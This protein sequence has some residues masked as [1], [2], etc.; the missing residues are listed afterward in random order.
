[1]EDPIILEIAF[2]HRVHP[3]GICLKR[4]VQRGVVPIPMSTKRENYLANL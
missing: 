1:M 4:A 2:K 3:A